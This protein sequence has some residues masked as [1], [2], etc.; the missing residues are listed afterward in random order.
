[1]LYEDKNTKNSLKK[2]ELSSLLRYK[3][4]TAILFQLFAFI[5][6]GD[7]VRSCKPYGIGEKKVI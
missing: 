2:E 4:E 3:K 5:E 1:M 7:V 6:K